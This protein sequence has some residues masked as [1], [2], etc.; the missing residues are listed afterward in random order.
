MRDLLRN[1]KT[2]IPLLLAVLLPAI[3]FSTV[4]AV[5]TPY[6][7]ENSE[8]AF[9]H[10]AAGRRSVPE[11]VSKTFPLTL[12][13]WRDHFADKELVFHFLLKGYC[14]IKS[15]FHSEVFPPFNGAAAFF[16]FVFL[17]AFLKAADWLGV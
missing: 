11:M 6:G 7:Q 5:F 10:V 13:V 2:G 12:S 17:I 16:F 1:R 9:W 15:L 3:L 8:D 4:R 14:G